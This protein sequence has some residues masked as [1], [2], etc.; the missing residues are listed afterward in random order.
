MTPDYGKRYEKSK[1]FL[2]VLELVGVEFFD[3]ATAC[4]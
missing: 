4:L 3:F 2:C 1:C